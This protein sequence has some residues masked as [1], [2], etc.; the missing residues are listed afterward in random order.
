MANLVPWCELETCTNNI[1]FLQFCHRWCRWYLTSRSAVLHIQSVLPHSLVIHSTLETVFTMSSASVLEPNSSIQH[2]KDR[3]AMELFELAIE[4][5]LHGSMSDAV[6]YY[7]EAFKIND[8]IDRLYRQQQVPKA[9]EK[10]QQEHG[11]NVTRKVDEEKLKLINV[12]QLLKLF[13]HEEFHPPDPNNPDHYDESHMAIKFA[14][15]GIDGGDEIADAKPVLPLLHL[16]SEVWLYTLEIL[17]ATDPELWFAFGIT[18]KKHAYLAFA[19]SA[20]WRRLCY[21]VYPKLVYEENVGILTK[22]LPVPLDPLAYLPLYGNSWKQILFER[23]FVKFLGCYISVVNYYSEGARPEFSLS[24][25]NPVRTVTYYRYMRFYPGGECVMALTALEPAKVIPQLLR[26]NQLKCILAQPELRDSSHIVA[27]KEPHKIFKGEWTISTEGDVNI[28]VDQGSV[29]YYTFYYQFQVKLLGGA[30]KHGKLSWVR[31]YAIRKK[32][33]DN[34]DRE[35][36]QVEFSMKN[37]KPFKFLR[38]RSYGA[39]N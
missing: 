16:P 6:R 21:S 8:Q 18:C 19:Q 29:P 4:K 15:M 12:D 13:E 32:M 31:Y 33:A 35:G 22:E 17:L 25:T 2:D 26:K 11:K 10:L 3:Q 36:E 30:V 34:D 14:N 37:E 24:W 39:D 9:V 20:I 28:R 7:R 5:E 27:A 23:P 38:V 1:I